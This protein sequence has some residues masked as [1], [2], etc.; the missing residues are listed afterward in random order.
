MEE[1]Q[2]KVSNTLGVITTN[3]EEIEA[4][5]KAVAADYKGIVVTEDTVKESK[6]DVAQLR[7]IIKEIEDSRKAVKKQWNAPYV[8]FE[9]RCK[10]LEALI[11]EPINEINEQVAVFE[12]KKIAEKQAHCMELYNECIGEYGDYLPFETI[13]N[14]KWDNAT[15]SDKDIKYDISE[16]VTKVRSEIDAIKALNSEIEDECLRVY[17]NSGNLLTAAIQKNSDY[18]SAK[19][20]AEKKIAEERQIEVNPIA[21]TACQP[22]EPVDVWEEPAFTFRVTGEDAIKRVKEMLDFAEI[23]YVEV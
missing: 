4:N 21:P 5:L 10:Q 19:S 15:Y 22:S 1:L 14:P 23:K 3:F 17:K 9:D 6:K 8:Q 12:Q 16:K 2:I 20:M 13:K 11:E 18:L 7:K